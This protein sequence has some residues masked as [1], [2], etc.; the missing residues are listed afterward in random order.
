MFIIAEFLSAKYAASKGQTTIVTAVSRFLSGAKDRDGG[1]SQ[2][3]KV[4]HQQ[5]PPPSQD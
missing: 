2:R 5:L 3:Q 4:L 1:R